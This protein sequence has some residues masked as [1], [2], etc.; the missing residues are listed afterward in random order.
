MHPPTHALLGYLLAELPDFEARR[1]RLLVFGAGLFPDVDGLTALGGAEFYQRYHHVLLHNVAGAVGYATL[2][3]LLATRR[4]T[5]FG[6]AL[7]GYHLHLLCDFLGSA[8]PDGSGWS[9]PY[10]VPFSFH[11]FYNAHQWGLASWQNVTVTIAAILVSIHLATRRGRTL[12]EFVSTRADGEVVKV[13]RRRWPWGGA[14]TAAKLKAEA[15]PDR[16]DPE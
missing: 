5:V 6:L 8:G 11:D 13:F 7:V 4:W 2:A 15:P 3:A 14:P 10:L 1:D 9:I 12:L 16:A